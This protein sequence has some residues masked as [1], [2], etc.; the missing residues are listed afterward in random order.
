MESSGGFGKRNGIPSAPAPV[1]S[2][3]RS[4]HEAPRG[5]PKPDLPGGLTVHGA[6]Q[7]AQGALAEQAMSKLHMADIAGLLKGAKAAAGGTA[8]GEVRRLSA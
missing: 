3:W 2:H 7:A 4:R 6:A 1:S 5:L 8:L